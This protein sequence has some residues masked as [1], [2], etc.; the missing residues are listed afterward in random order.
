MTMPVN[1]NGYTLS[2]AAGLTFGTSGTKIVAANYG[3][4]DP[5][6]PGMLGSATDG[7]ATYKVYPY[8]VNDVNI[9]IGSC[10]SGSTFRFTA[11]VAGIYYVSYSGIVG[12]GTPTQTAGYYAVI[13]N[14]ANTYWGYKDTVSIWELMHIEILF[15]L[16][17]GDTVSWA[18]NASPGPV[19]GYPGGAYRSNHNTCTIWLVG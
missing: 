19:S 1:I 5:M 9:N 10:W 8:P 12:D 15:K 3:I 6:L 14:G 11:P 2:E 4:R 16:A 17:A 7:S 13:V 18:M